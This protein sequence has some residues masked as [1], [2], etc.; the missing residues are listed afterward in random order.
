MNALNTIVSLPLNRVQG[1]VVFSQS[2]RLLSLFWN[3]AISLFQSL[4]LSSSNSLMRSNLIWDTFF[5][6]FFKWC[7]FS[8][9]FWYNGTPFFPLLSTKCVTLLLISDLVQDGQFSNTMFQ[10]ISV[11]LT[12]FLSIINW[13]KFFFQFRFN[14]PLK[15]AKTVG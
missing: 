10:S 11:R 3:F 2:S 4:F 5:L 13:K 6:L 8:A 7:R 1:S 14:V 15:W 12:Y 9:K